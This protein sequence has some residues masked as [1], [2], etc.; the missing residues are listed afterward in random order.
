MMNLEKASGLPIELTPDFHLKFHAPLKDQEPAVRTIEEMKPVLLDRETSSTRDEMYYMY[1]DVHMPDHESIIRPSGARYDITVIPP[2]MI[3]GEFNKTVG[4]YHPMKEGTQFAY[5]EVYEILNGKGLI[6]LQKMDAKFDEVIAVI[7]LEVKQGDKIVYPPNYGHILINLGDEPLVTSNWVA[8]EFT[9]L[10]QQVVDYA[11]M[12][13]YVVA[14]KEKGY[15]F[16]PNSKYKNHPPVRM[17]TTKFMNRFE[18]NQPGP[19]YML[20]VSNVKSL[21]FLTHPEKY[22]VELSSITS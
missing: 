18:I 14:D 15:K 22:S 4:H 12:A 17:I 7:V 2:A 6:F 3:G 9:S 11:G 20:G 16:V 19:M 5:P 21:E 10:Y 13:Y 1:R 8:G